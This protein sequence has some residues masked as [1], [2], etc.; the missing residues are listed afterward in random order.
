[1]KLSRL[2]AFNVLSLGGLA[3]GASTLTTGGVAVTTMGGC[4]NSGES[5]SGS[6]SSSGSS[7]GGIAS[8]SGVSSSGGEGGACMTGCMFPTSGTIAINLALDT[9]WVGTNV[10]QGCD[11]GL[12]PDAAQRTITNV[13][14]LNYTGLDPSTGKWTGKFKT[15]HSKTPPVTLTDTG[16]ALVGE[17]SG[18]QVQIQVPDST[19]DAPEQPDI[20]ITGTLVSSTGVMT[21]DP[22]VT[23]DG[24]KQ[25]S[26]WAD[27][28]KM[29]PP[30]APTSSMMPAIPLSDLSD[31]DGNGYGYGITGA[32]RSDMGF[33][34]PRTA[35]TKT[36]PQADA[37][38]IALRVQFILNGCMNTCTTGT[39]TGMVPHYD[40]HLIGCHL[41]GGGDAATDYCN[42]TQYNFIDANTT[43]YVVNTATFRSKIVT[44]GTGMG[45]AVTCADVRNAMP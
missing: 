11:T 21:L 15:C 39:G 41:Q 13:L 32:A 19:W 1:M 44:T 16:A 24:I 8:S 10:I 5:S 23:L 30:P 29:W 26:S 2:W 17:P 27:V 28:S 18:T 38:Y 35:L 3:L 33:F 14:A 42:S 43:N 12:C 4:S 40:N 22:I 37:L 25:G 9:S 7:S 6:G 45:G 36:A 31:D 20:A 34:V